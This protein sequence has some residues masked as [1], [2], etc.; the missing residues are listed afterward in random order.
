MKAAFSARFRNDEDLAEARARSW[1]LSLNERC[2]EA[3]SMLILSVVELARRSAD[4]DDLEARLD[5]EPPG[6]PTDRWRERRMTEAA[7]KAG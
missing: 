7:S 1:Q 3:V 6:C 5:R 2:A 4:R